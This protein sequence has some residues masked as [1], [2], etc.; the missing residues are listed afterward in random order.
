[1]MGTQI[2]EVS[3]S[4]GFLSSCLDTIGLG[5]LATVLADVQ[6][7]LTFF[8]L[9][10]LFHLLFF[11]K[12]KV[13]KPKMP[14]KQ[15]KQKAA[16]AGIV[17]LKNAIR[18]N[19]IK[20]AMSHF[21]ALHGMFQDNDSPSS[22]PSLVMERLIKLAAQDNALPE[23]LGRMADQ[24]FVGNALDLVL[25]E[26][27]ALQDT[28]TFKEA[29]RLGRAKGATFTSATYSALIKGASLC[30]IPE[31]AKR[32]MKE[33]V[34]LELADGATYNTYIKGLLKNGEMREVRKVLES[35]RCEGLSSNRS[36]DFLIN[37]IVFNGLLHEAGKFNAD[38]AWSLFET[39]QGLGVK[40]DQVTCSVLLKFFTPTTKAS[41]L[42]SVMACL[43]A[44]EEDIDE[45]LVGGSLEAC[46]RVG[47]AD[48][49]VPLL[50]KLDA[51][52]HLS[53]KNSHTFGSVIRAY[54]YT[55]DVKGAWRTWREMK[56][57]HISPI[58][59]TVGCMVEALTTNGDMEAGYELI[60]ELWQD[61]ATKG[62][63]NAVI[64]GSLAKGFAQKR[65]FSRVW[66]VYDEMVARHMKFSM[67][68]FNTLI[69]ACAR[70]GDLSR[71]PL[72]LKDIDAQ[73]LKV[74]L[75]TYGAILKGY[76][77]VNRLNEAFDLV[78]DMKK[79]TNLEPD[80]IMYN[81][82]LDGC[83]RQGLYDRGMT[84]LDS[85]KASGVRPSNFT[86]SVLVKMANRSKKLE[87]AFEMCE[88][89]CSQ[90]NFRMNVHVFNNLIQAC[91]QHQE[92]PRAL[93]VLEHMLQE[94][95][96]PDARTYSMLLR[97]CVELKRSEDAGGLLR[98]AFGLSGA[99]P[100]TSKAR[101]ASAQPQGGLPGELVSEIL[102]A[103]MDRCRA[104]DVAASLLVDLSRS[105]PYL[106]FDPKL[107]L[108]LT[109]RMAASEPDC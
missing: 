92:F 24:G 44:F 72:L 18:G 96:K 69:D 56:R 17:A 107:R 66:E 105:A 10:F 89:L 109:A 79:T 64:Y 22:A 71:I 9:A 40:A 32:Y 58:S 6:T 80:E 57:L 82:L 62:L 93:D 47:R 95:V 108:R 53:I 29:E 3:R 11:H 50:K 88:E 61:D 35:M 52:P 85:M 104:E 98:S 73:G 77:Q 97:G 14:P 7:E 76:C 21:E 12:L 90:Y 63:V 84:V 34:G 99:H 36:G 100:C 19:D 16:A 38:H 74:G 39:M 31:E 37:A 55:H 54:G 15:Q 28:A 67:V 1:M 60:Q 23:L 2:S 51:S 8:A 101:G 91:I 86:L 106:K 94:R 5:A 49:L 27:A 26:S 30:G 78:E 42:E 65:C 41:C 59:V 45:V 68:T 81:T 33:A 43:A 70:S 83:A 20:A 46:L 87:R 13:A 48:L 102:L 75:I 4:P 25:A 103:L